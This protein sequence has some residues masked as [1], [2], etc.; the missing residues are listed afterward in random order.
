MFV[1]LSWEVK[2]IGPRP[3]PITPCAPLKLWPVT[4]GPEV[5]N[6]HPKESFLSVVS[7]VEL[8]VLSVIVSLEKKP[9]EV[10]PSA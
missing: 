10:D 8:V 2:E 3:R 6:P 9:V 7:R 4:L 5:L 1:L